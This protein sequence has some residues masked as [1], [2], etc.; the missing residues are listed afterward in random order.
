MITAE[1]SAGFITD[2]ISGTQVKATPEEVEAVQVFARR[3]VEDYGYPAAHIQTDAP[4]G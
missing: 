1:N 3:L 2:F 4:F